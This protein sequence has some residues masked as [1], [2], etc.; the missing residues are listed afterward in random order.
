MTPIL[1]QTEYD[2]EPIG[3]PS[4]LSFHRKKPKQSEDVFDKLESGRPKLRSKSFN[5]K[6]MKLPSRSQSFNVRMMHRPPPEPLVVA[7]RY[8]PSRQQS[9][10]MRLVTIGL[11]T[12]L[13]TLFVA[14]SRM[15]MSTHSESSPTAQRLRMS[16]VMRRTAQEQTESDLRSQVAEEELLKSLQ[17]EMDKQAELQTQ[18]EQIVQAR[19]ASDFD[20]Q[21]QGVSEKAVFSKFG[22]GPYRVEVTMANSEFFVLEMIS[23]KEMPHTVHH[24]LEMVE[25][26]LWDGMTLVHGMGVHSVHAIPQNSRGEY[27]QKQFDNVRLGSLPFE[28]S[29]GY[30]DEKYTVSFSKRRGPDFYI[31]LQDNT[32]HNEFA[33][34]FAKV[35]EGF[36]VLDRIIDGAGNLDNMRF[37]N[38]EQMRVL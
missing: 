18:L 3:T 24:F 27:A 13:I 33:S 12:L 26:G 15:T 17:V 25:Y 23:V 36:D 8:V 4:K 29:G 34:C 14:L 30:P 11:F 9:V 22:T 32:E 19:T 1:Y 7:R 21:L 16:S 37:F 28:E 35:V 20:Q 10:K 5:A 2:Q 38:I 31:N 6:A